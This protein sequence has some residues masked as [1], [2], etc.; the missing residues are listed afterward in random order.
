MTNDTL[1]RLITLALF[2]TAFTISGYFRSKANRESNERVSRREEGLPILVLL[3]LAGSAAWLSVVVYMINPEWMKWSTLPLPDA[4]RW[5]GAALSAAAIPLV[6]WMFR[7]LGGNITDT[8]ATRQK[9]TLVTRGPYRWIR[10]PLYS[11]GTLF[12]IGI[13]LM[14]ANWFILLTAAAALTILLLRTPI[15]EAKLIEKFGGEYRAYARRTGRFF[16]RLSR[17]SNRGPA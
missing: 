7:S 17:S 12:F 6:F 2:V 10:H 5:L 1:F 16:P 3:R 8:V 13:I 11:F 15:E 9:H 14:S 4:L